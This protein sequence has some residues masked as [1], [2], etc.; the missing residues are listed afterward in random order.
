MK[1]IESSTYK[2]I[3]EVSLNYEKEIIREIQRSKDKKA[4][5]KLVKLYDKMV[6]SLIY[7]FLNNKEDAMELTQDVFI[8]VY[9]KINQYRGDAP[10]YFWLQKIAVNF[11]LNKIRSYKKDLLKMADEIKPNS[12]FEKNHSSVPVDIMEDNERKD[13]VRECLSKVPLIYRMAVILKDIEGASYE[14]ISKILKCSIGTVKSRIS[15]GREE[16]RLILYC[17]KNEVKEYGM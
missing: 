16:L 4:F 11:C 3:E 1:D 14:E 12:V 8:R 9:L 15:R 17:Y 7:R 10:F 13:F 6:F 2:V 5:Y